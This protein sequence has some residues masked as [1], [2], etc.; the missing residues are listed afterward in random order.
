[1]ENEKLA[2]GQSDVDCRDDFLR[3]TLIDSKR[4][5]MA[6]T[7]LFASQLNGNRAPLRG[8]RWAG[9]EFWDKQT[10]PTL[11]RCALERSGNVFGVD[12]AVPMTSGG[13]SSRTLPRDERLACWSHAWCHESV[14]QRR[15]TIAQRCRIQGN[16]NYH[17]Q[18]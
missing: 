16:G 15:Q 1:L 9:S 5:G 7:A 6:D 13:S 12:A 3:S 10:D 8:D 11:T 4:K 2:A 17:C 18:Q 14:L